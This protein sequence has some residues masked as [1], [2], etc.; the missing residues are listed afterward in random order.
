M[1]RSINFGACV[2]K[3]LIGCVL[4]IAI[5]PGVSGQQQKV[6][7][8][9]DQDKDVIRQRTSVVTVNVSVTDKQFRQIG[10]LT[11]EH[12]EIYEDKVRQQIEYF[13]DEDKPASVGI[14]FDLS[15]SMRDKMPRARE[16]LKAFVDTCHNDDDFFLVTF[17][18]RATL[19]AGLSDGQN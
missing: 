6:I 4:L 10:G 15:G 17:N 14:L 16:A 5:Q 8:D 9:Q 12:F 19:M 3:A 11:K 13:S 1:R 7:Q 18:D 2:Y